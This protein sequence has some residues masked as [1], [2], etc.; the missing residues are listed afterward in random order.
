MENMAVNN[1]NRNALPVFVLE[2]STAE[3]VGR[4]MIESGVQNQPFYIFDL[5]EAFRRIQNFRDVMPRV[6]LFYGK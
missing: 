4:A 1:L 5:D 2:D 6:K 3:D